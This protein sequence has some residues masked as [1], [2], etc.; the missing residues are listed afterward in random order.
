MR[1][2]RAVPPLASPASDDDEFAVGHADSDSAEDESDGEDD[3]DSR[4]VVAGAVPVP[5]V[6]RTQRIPSKRYTPPPARSHAA[7]WAFSA[8]ILPLAV[9]VLGNGLAVT[10]S[11]DAV[12][13]TEAGVTTGAWAPVFVTL[14]IVFVLNAALLTVCAVMGSRAFRE[15]A[16]GITKG[17]GLAIAGFAVGGLNL[18]LW[19]VGLV[20]TVGGFSTALG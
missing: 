13:A 4:D 17:R 20:L 3:E 15:T 18:I 7:T 5:A 6:P 14:A 2:L 9:S 1:L 19:V 8:G 16:N 12:A 11:I 10:L